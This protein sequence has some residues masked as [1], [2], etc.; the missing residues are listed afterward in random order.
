[1][2]RPQNGLAH[3]DTYGDVVAP[4]YSRMDSQEKRGSFLSRTILI[5]LQHRLPELLLM[6]VDKMTMAT[7]VEARVPYLDHELVEFA[8]GIPS[9]LKYRRGRTKHILKEAAR[10]ILPDDIIDRPKTGFC[11]GVRNMIA[12]PVAEHASQIIT[13]SQ[14]L[15]TIVEM[16]PVNAMLARS[17][18]GRTDNSAAIWALMN[19]ALWHSRWIE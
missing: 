18:R 12:G 19:L 9:N 8:L 14:W 1:M 10:G 5:E 16:E 7:S 4:I 13:G 17:R 3:V 2:L 11:G 15:Q 6:R